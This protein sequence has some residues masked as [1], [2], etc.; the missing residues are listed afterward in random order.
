MRS[1][2][3][4]DF[5]HVI[6]PSLQVI[7]RGR[8]TRIYRPNDGACDGALSRRPPIR[9]WS[10]G[11]L[12]VIRVAARGLPPVDLPPSAGRP[13]DRGA[14]PA[15]RS[16]SRHGGAEQPPALRLPRRRPELDVVGRLGASGSGGRQVLH[17]G[18]VH[19][20]ELHHGRVDDQFRG[21]SN[22]RHDIMHA[23]MAPL[24]GFGFIA[25]KC[26]F[27]RGAGRGSS[28]APPP[29]A[30]RCMCTLP[31]FKTLAMRTN[32][33]L[34]CGEVGS[35]LCTTEL[36]FDAPATQALGVGMHTVM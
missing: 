14:V 32:S 35:P 25:C 7:T 11:G 36:E 28:A 4:D 17:V 18:G 10:T 9:H 15:A 12:P 29:P 8:V 21:R 1:P 22:A 20:P 30:R 6:C 23:C 33:A 34:W 2:D 19:G 3:C 13:V 5:S 27:S 31:L 24:L 26:I 16:A